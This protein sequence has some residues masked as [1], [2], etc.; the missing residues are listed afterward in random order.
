MEGD[1]ELQHFWFFRNKDA[2]DLL[3]EAAQEVADTPFQVGSLCRVITVV[4][5]NS[6]LVMPP[7]DSG[8][9]AWIVFC[10]GDNK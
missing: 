2:T 10:H 4:V 1:V 9:D 8:V 6:F 7:R 5:I 3:G